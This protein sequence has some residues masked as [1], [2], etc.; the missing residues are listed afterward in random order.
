MLM[1]LVSVSV[2]FDR[3]G[4][5]LVQ[6][7][8]LLERGFAITQADACLTLIGRDDQQHA[9]LAANQIMFA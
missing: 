4:D 3:A 7:R 5:Q 1:P 9:T 6:D 8:R 2:S